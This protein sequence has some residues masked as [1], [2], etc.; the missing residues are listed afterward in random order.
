MATTDDETTAE[1][2][3]DGSNSASV[4]PGWVRP[5]KRYGPFVAVA[6]LIAAAVAVFGAGDDGD[7][8]DANTG[9][10][11]ASAVIDQD[12]LIRSGPMTPQRAE[13]EGEEDVD[14]GPQCDADTGRIMLPTVYA[15]PCVVPFDGDNGG[16]TSPGVTGDEILVV[17]Y[18]TDPSVDPLLSAQVAATGA[19]VNP[20]TAVQTTEGY[21]DLF[22]QVFETYGRT[23]QVVPFTGS[24][25]SDDTDA[26]RADAIEIAE[27]GAFAVAGGPQRATP[28][29]ATALADR[30]V[31]C[32]S[33]CA[34][35]VPEGIVRAN[36]PYI[37]P[38]AGTPN[39]NAALAAEMIGKLAGP[40]PAELAGDEAMRTEDRVYALAYYDNLDGDY[41][42]VTEALEDGLAEQ[43][44]DLAT[45][46][47][48]ELDLPRMQETVRSMVAQ[49]EEAGVTTVIFSGDPLTPDAMTAEATA[50]DYY[51]EWILAQS[52]LADTALFGRTFEQ[53]QW[54]NGFGIGLPPARGEEETG[55][56]YRVY[57][58]AYGTA[59][60]NNTYNILA[61][62][63]V[64][65]FSGIHLAGP[66]LTPETFRDGLFRNPPTGGGPTSVQVS[67]G[68]HGVWPEL[69]L[70]G[71]DDATIIWWDPDAEGVD[72]TGNEGVGLYRYA[73][74]GERYTLGEFP[75]SIEEAGLFDEDA[76][77][78]IYDELPADDQ[79]PDYPPPDL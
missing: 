31:L 25:A 19:E 49:L 15:P 29:F 5:V 75:E 17:R 2:A 55:D 24:G 66:E 69:D 65:I 33:T 43:G 72:E 64:T 28:A 4:P 61:P 70:G 38:F 36:Q 34:T 32:I 16:A 77:V 78:T 71:V 54:I 9:G 21:V 8:E 22:Q 52:V 68:D 53:D 50:Q 14:F 3:P 23:V 73:N 47:R 26:A 67:R 39:Q 58:W 79:V 74:G 48:F 51:P 1:P 45:S 60:P 20:E 35:A 10:D 12:E 40:G 57:D 76:S 13:L 42:E 59:P 56:W 44:I 7:D 41:Q 27:M 62:A 46:L 37:I 18:D 63:L 30:G 6:I 11:E